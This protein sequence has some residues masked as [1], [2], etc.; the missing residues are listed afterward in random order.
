MQ[1][2]AVTLFECHEVS[3]LQSNHSCFH[4]YKNCNNCAR[5]VK[6]NS[7]KHGATFFYGPW[8]M[9]RSIFKLARTWAKHVW[10]AHFCCVPVICFTCPASHNTAFNTAAVQLVWSCQVLGVTWCCI[11]SQLASTNDGEHT[12]RGF[13]HDSTFEFKI[14]YSGQ[15]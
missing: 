10:Q 4:R 11:K 5:N 14:A 12:G 1:C 8:C 15:H 3:R 2:A 9:L 6:S 7:R 13:W